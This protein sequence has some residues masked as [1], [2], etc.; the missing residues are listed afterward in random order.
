MSRHERETLERWVQ[1]FEQKQK[2]RALEAELREA[3][4]WGGTMRRLFRS[5]F[6]SPAR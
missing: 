6:R 3:S 1:V 5:L 4:T 2:I